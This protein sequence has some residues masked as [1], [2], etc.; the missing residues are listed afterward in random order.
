MEVEIQKET[1]FILMMFL[2]LHIKLLKME[3]MEK[4]ITLQV[5]RLFLFVT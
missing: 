5:M 4:F 2:M 1:L 3:K